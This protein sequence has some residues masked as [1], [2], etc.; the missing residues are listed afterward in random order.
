MLT[1]VGL[2]GLRGQLAHGHAVTV[3]GSENASVTTQNRKLD[4]FVKEKWSRANRATEK[5][6]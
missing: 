5:N 3:V 6:V 2:N 1:E 4:A